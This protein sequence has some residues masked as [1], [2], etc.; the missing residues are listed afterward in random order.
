MRGTAD[1]EQLLREKLVLLQ[2]D[3]VMVQIFRTQVVRLRSSVLSGCTEAQ[4]RPQGMDGLNPVGTT[5]RCCLTTDK[6]DDGGGNHSRGR[7]LQGERSDFQQ[8]EK[9]P[10]TSE[11]ER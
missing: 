11:R 6:G 4:W 8:R 1:G 3:N 9:S 10:Q 5:S 7:C 2:M